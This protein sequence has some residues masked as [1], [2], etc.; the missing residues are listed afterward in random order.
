MKNTKKFCCD[1]MQYNATNHC[2]VHDSPY[3]CPDRLIVYDEVRDGYGIVIHD[4]GQSYI[5]IKY[6][7]WCGKKLPKPKEINLA[8]YLEVE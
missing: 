6:C 8:D 3:E 1:M 7:P 2:H 4:G 5:S